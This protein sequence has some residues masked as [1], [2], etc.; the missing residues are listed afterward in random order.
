MAVCEAI[1]AAAIARKPARNA[2]LSDIMA[3]L[4]YCE[5]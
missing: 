3:Y 2:E 4:L 5:A 1:A